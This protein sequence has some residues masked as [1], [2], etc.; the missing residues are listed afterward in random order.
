MKHAPVQEPPSHPRAFIYQLVYLRINDLN[1]HP[2]GERCHTALIF[3]IDPYARRSLLRDSY[4]HRDLPAPCGYQTRDS[5]TI[6]AIPNQG[7][8]GCRPE[9]PPS[10]QNENSLEQAGLARGIFSENQI[11]T[12]GFQSDLRQTPNIFRG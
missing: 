11:A 5:Q 12:G 4:T 1:G 9:R 10:S 6:L 7:I 2:L 3:A 8:P